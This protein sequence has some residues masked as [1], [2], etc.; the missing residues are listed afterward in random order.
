MTHSLRSTPKG[1]SVI[2]QNILQTRRFYFPFQKGKINVGTL[3][4]VLPDGGGEA[5]HTGYS[6]PPMANSFYL[7]LKTLQLIGFFI[8]LP[9]L[10]PIGRQH[11]C[12]RKTVAKDPNV[13]TVKVFL[14][15]TVSVVVGITIF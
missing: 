5:P 15:K 7:R 3:R 2:K 4:W 1:A 11:S 12:F 9:K 6:R 10:P 8:N 14:C 13:R